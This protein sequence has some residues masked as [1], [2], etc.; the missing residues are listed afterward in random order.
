ME[1]YLETIITILIG[2]GALLISVV[3]K[4]SVKQS[5]SNLGSHFDESIWDDEY[6][7]NSNIKPKTHVSVE[8]EYEN[9]NKSKSIAMSEDQSSINDPPVVKRKLK[10]PVDEPLKIK[11]RRFNGKQAII[12]NAIIS[13]KYD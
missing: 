1:D 7:T 13:R 3:R 12:Y 9:I 5:P 11:P 10:L 2:L 8:N 4:K 6:E